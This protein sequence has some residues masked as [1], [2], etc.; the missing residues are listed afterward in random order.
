MDEK[1]ARLIRVENAVS[2][3]K[4]SQTEFFF[5]YQKN[6]LLILS[7][8]EMISGTQCQQCI[9]KLARQIK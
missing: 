8:Q 4:N 6:I 7:E 3:D 9:E 2:I 5:E 1:T